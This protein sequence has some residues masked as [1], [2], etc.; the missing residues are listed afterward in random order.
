M[1]FGLF[2]LLEAPSC[3]YGGRIN[4]QTADNIP[5]VY[6]F[7][8]KKRRHDVIYSFIIAITIL[9]CSV[10]FTACGTLAGKIMNSPVFTVYD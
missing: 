5:P 8:S 9:N 1:S 4:L 2:L 10:A 3:K 6:L 7:P